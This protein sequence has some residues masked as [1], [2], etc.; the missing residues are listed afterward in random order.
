MAGAG[1][2]TAL[3]PFALFAH[4]AVKQGPQASCHRQVAKSAKKRAT[5]LGCG[6]VPPFVL[7]VRGKWSLA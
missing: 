7:F 5:D 3:R 1:P 6:D 2:A 4:F